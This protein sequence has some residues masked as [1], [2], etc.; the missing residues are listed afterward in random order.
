MTTKAPKSKQA[1]GPY[2]VGK[3]KAQANAQHIAA[4]RLL[5][6][7]GIG[8]VGGFGAR[9]FK[10]FRDMGSE[11]PTSVMPNAQIPQPFTFK[12]VKPEEEKVAGWGE[13][14]AGWGEDV[15]NKATD[16]LAKALPRTNTIN[17][18]ANEWGIPATVVGVGGG[19]YGG[20]KLLDWLLDA[21]KNQNQT[22]ELQ[23]AETDYESA[24]AEQYRAAMQSKRASD[25]LGID[26]LY[27]HQVELKEKTASASIA[28]RLPFGD[29]LRAAF[30]AP[31]YIP[32]MGGNDGYEFSKGVENTALLTL[33]GGVGLGTYNHTR[34]RSKE[35]LVAEALKQRQRQ[36]QKLS[37]PPLLALPQNDTPKPT[38]AA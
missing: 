36:R 6:A 4:R 21:E 28:E 32:G 37:P 38:I 15:L 24:L 16:G 9:A 7:L 5:S 1:G 8:A 35:N 17:P 18:L 10:E 29:A 20:Y 12:P 33:L 19:A 11:P 27:D 2:Y 30:S 26:D 22:D 23:D 34:N 13:D 14:V 3:P 25:D 31:F